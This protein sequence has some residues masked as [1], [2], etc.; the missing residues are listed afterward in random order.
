MC[1]AER[2]NQKAKH[3]KKTQKTTKKKKESLTHEKKCVGKNTQKASFVSL[4]RER[5][6]R[7]KESQ[8]T[9]QSTIERRGKERKIGGFLN[10]FY[11]TTRKKKMNRKGL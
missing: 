10:L 6:V 11:Q 9:F 5:K 4:L 2:G 3:R 8:G 7:A 1:K